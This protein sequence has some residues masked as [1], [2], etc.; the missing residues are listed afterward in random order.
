MVLCPSSLT[1]VAAASTVASAVSVMRRDGLQG[2]PCG[3]M[4]VDIL[5]RRTQ[6]SRVLVFT[7]LNT[8][9]QNNIFLHCCKSTDKL[10]MCRNVSCKQCFQFSSYHCITR[11]VYC[12]TSQ[13]LETPENVFFVQTQDLFCKKCL[14]LFIRSGKLV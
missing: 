14:Q 4:D 7:Q 11:F 2:V 6:W 1:A 5:D 9:I 13:N 12:G 8:K 3:T 10:Y